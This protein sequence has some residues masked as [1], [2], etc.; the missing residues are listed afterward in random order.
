MDIDNILTQ[1]EQNNPAVGK[2]ARLAYAASLAKEGR[3]EARSERFSMRISRRQHLNLHAK[4]AAA[5]MTAADLIIQ[6]LGL[7][8]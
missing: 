7:D 5:G 2:A 1:L 4:A 6:K 8:K 3:A